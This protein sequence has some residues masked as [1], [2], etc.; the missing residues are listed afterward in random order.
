[1]SERDLEARLDAVER[2]LTD[3]G[4]DL[5]DL[6][7][8]SGVVDDLADLERRVE[9]IE[10]RLDELEAGLQAVRGYAGNVRA[11]NREVERRASAAL[12]KAEALETAVEDGDVRTDPS[13]QQADR[14]HSPERGEAARR[15]VDRPGA[16]PRRQPS[17]AGARGRS[18][19][20][21]GRTG[22]GRFADERGQRPREQD[23]G[24][25]AV[26]G[27]ES[28]DAS[29]STGAEGKTEQFVERVRDAL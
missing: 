23:E 17:D 6:R 24:T 20:G 18:S 14:A 9:R 25:G 8:T 5:T 15:A 2:A 27:D 16:P 28:D 19:T 26:H 22:D 1:M 7:E 4:T 3:D 21:S 10:S 29:R 11:V 12:A 13:D